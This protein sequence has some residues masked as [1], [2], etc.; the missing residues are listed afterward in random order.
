MMK[1]I[2]NFLKSFRKK[3]NTDNGADSSTSTNNASDDC[4]EL[5]LDFPSYQNQEQLENKVC[6]NEGEKMSESYN[7][8][9]RDEMIDRE[10]ELY[11]T[12]RQRSERKPVT[13]VTDIER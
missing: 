8:L 1:K 6:N 10:L 9:S 7:G 13:K 5:V 11:F 2:K 12:K 4:H 3:N